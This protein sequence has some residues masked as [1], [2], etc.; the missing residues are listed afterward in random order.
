MPS[1]DAVI[2][3]FFTVLGSAPL[4]LRA[5]CS[6]EVPQAAP[7]V[8]LSGR[9]EHIQG[10]QLF[11]IARED[12]SGHPL[13]V[14][15]PEAEDGL[16]SGMRVTVRGT[17]QHC[18]DIDAKRLG[19]CDR[20][21]AS[22]RDEAASDSVLVARSMVTSARYDLR[23]AAGI[24]VQ[25]DS[26]FEG[27]RKDVPMTVRPDALAALVDTLAGRSIRVPSTRVVGVF[28]PRVFLV[29]SQA[30]LLPL[31]DR[32]R[33]LVFIE[34][35][36]LRVEPALLVGSTVTLFGVARTL[37][38]MQVNADVP[39]PTVLTPDDVKRLDIRAAILA[40]S[41]QTP[42]GIDLVVR[43][44]PNPKPTQLSPRDR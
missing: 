18:H 35:G 5:E 25:Q 12:D 28:D 43:S 15:L 10:P 39:W 34:P 30:R 27:P 24:T 6:W 29:E 11:T 7:E 16:L 40:K 37:L 19:E 1:R 17:L 20:F 33:V 42:E 26:V 41:V 2:A 44:S 31:V 23:G 4:S 3:V 36:R 8:T 22:A 32:N 13:L 38:G 14:F 9:V 21:D